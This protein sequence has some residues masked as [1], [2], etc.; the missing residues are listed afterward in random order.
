[1]NRQEINKTESLYLIDTMSIA[2]HERLKESLIKMLMLFN[3]FECVY[4]KDKINDTD[5]Y[6]IID[7]YT[8][9]ESLIIKEFNFFKER[10]YNN[11]NFTN[12]FKTLNFGKDLKQKIG[13]SF[14]AN[15][16]KLFA[17]TR[18]AYKFRNNLYHGHKHICEL[19]KY[20]TCFENI[21]SFLIKFLKNAKEKDNG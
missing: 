10:Y 18:I 2:G 6:A 11:G 19:E 20:E 7:K 5:K 21:N 13:N 9:D 1:M 15:N 4:L 3:L 14:I 16:E 12:N 8:M 17:L